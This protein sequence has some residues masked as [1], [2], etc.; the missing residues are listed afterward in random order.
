MIQPIFNFVSSIWSKFTENSEKIS[1]ELK[2][3][4]NQQVEISQ[5]KK[6]STILQEILNS[7][8]DNTTKLLWPPNQEYA[9]PVEINRPLTL[10]GQGATI[11]ALSGPVI[12]INS[13]NVI[14]RNFRI[15]VTGSE[16]SNNSAKNCAIEVKNVNKLQFD[17]IE[18]RGI[19]M[20]LPSEEGEWKYP[21]SLYLGKLA[22]KTEYD[23]MLR[24]FVPVQCRV[25]SNIS[26]LEFS[27][28][29][30]EPGPNEIQIHLDQFSNDSL[31]N[32]D[33]FLVSP[34]LKRRIVITAHIISSSDNQQPH[35]QNNVI[36]EPEN[37]STLVS[38]PKAK[39]ELQNNPPENYPQEPNI[40]TPP[41]SSQPR[42]YETSIPE[43]D[44]FRLKTS[45]TSKKEPNKSNPITSQLGEA[46]QPKN[47]DSQNKP[48]NSSGSELQNDSQS[49][50]RKSN[51]SE[52]NSSQ[53]I[54]YEPSIPNTYIF[55]PKTSETSQEKPNKSNP[56]TSQLGEA[57]QPKNQDSQNK[58]EN[59]SG[60]KLQNDSQSHSRKSNPLDNLPPIFRNKNSDK[61][62]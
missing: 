10:D 16:F 4:L 11:W 57:F 35:S 7:L 18:V 55:R 42:T 45:E 62:E 13:N 54:P 29:N 39:E 46:F 17:N 59:S 25:Q 37:W 15:E 22:P 52:P 9:G 33:I 14:L 34:S 6:M 27:H 31:I 28:L 32:G 44:I 12:T 40:E 53:P 51:L 56:K 36:W 20:G 1:D 48:E 50:S 8:E 30:L 5:P 38:V 61:D 60:S 58:S 23:F 49:H 21:N 43:N 26:G 2:S 41:N 47:Q 3:N 24:I 19:V